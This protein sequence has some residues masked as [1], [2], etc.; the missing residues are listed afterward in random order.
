MFCKLSLSS[1]LFFEVSLK[2]KWADVQFSPNRPSRHRFSVLVWLFSAALGFWF[3]PQLS[4]LW[5]SC[6]QQNVLQIIHPSILNQIPNRHIYQA[7]TVFTTRARKRANVAL[8]LTRL[9]GKLVN[10]FIMCSKFDIQAILV[11]LITVMKFSWLS[12]VWF[13]IQTTLPH[14]EQHLW[15]Y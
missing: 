11:N 10:T 3:V 6:C 7:S 14:W 9:G 2:Q 1:S 4:L 12:P 13:W 15:E 8:S 5:S